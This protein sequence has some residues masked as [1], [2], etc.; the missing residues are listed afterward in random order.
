MGQP[1]VTRLLCCLVVLW[2]SPHVVEA[3]QIFTPPQTLS[4][5]PSGV[6]ISTNWGPGTPGMTDPLGFDRFDPTLGTLEAVYVTMTMTI[7]NDYILQ[8][9]NTPIMTTLYV[10]TSKTSDPSILTDPTKLA[11]LTDGPTVILNGPDGVTQI[12]DRRATTQPVDFLKLTKS[13]GT[14]SSLLD[15]SDPNYIS[16]TMTEHSFTRVLDASNAGTLPAQ[17]IGNGRVDLSLTAMAF[18]SFY[19]DSGNGGGTVLTRANASVT[20]QYLYSARAIPEPAA[21]VLATIGIGT[22]FVVCL[23]RRSIRRGRR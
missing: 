12:F 23:L 4:I 8:F 9:V 17:F 16:P 11:Q 13:S 6:L 5:A 15:P 21:S 7:R 3:G 22:S 10:A 20:I 14:W 2:L 1:R 18:S 19:S